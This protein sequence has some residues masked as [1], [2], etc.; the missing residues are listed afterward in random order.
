MID[1]AEPPTKITIDAV[2]LLRLALDLQANVVDPFRYWGK[3]FGQI[4]RY[5]SLKDLNIHT[6]LNDYYFMNGQLQ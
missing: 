4:F 5:L 1:F 2:T 6:Y 3:N